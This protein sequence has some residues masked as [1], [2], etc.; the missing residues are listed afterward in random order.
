MSILETATVCAKADKALNDKE[1]AA[2]LETLPFDKATFSKLLKIGST[3]R[4]REDSVRRLLPCSSS[5]IYSVALLEQDK[6]LTAAIE[7]G[8]LHSKATRAQIDAF[9][10]GTGDDDD[11][12][13][14]RDLAR[15]RVPADYDPMRA[16]ALIEALESLVG[17]YEAK[18]V[19]KVDA[20]ETDA[21]RSARRL[22]EY[23]AKKARAFLRDL[24]TALRHKRERWSF[25]GDG[26]RHFGK[27]SNGFRPSYQ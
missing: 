11:D 26:D 20:A 12:S 7:R 23:I 4:L 14:T 6:K 3:P 10:K 1:K 16:K 25:R 19:R 18:V 17:D 27:R 13:K 9:R 2:L 24:Q 21:S 8:V 22:R 5:T 15:I